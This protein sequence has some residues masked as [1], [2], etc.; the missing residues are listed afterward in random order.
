MS[1]QSDCACG[2]SC[3]DTTHQGCGCNAL[4]TGP[5]TPEQPCTACDRDRRNNVWVE[6]AV[7]S[8]GVG[9]ICLLDTLCEQQI[10]DIIQRDERARQ[11]L[12]RVTSNP[13][14]HKLAATVP[15]LPK[16][17]E[18]DELQKEINQNTIPFYTLF[19]GQ[20]PFAQ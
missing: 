6:G 19:R 15:R 13:E 11:D 4:P 5:V 3:P 17:N 1:C 9:G 8:N 7:D 2:G 16:V 18:G 14:L 12:C 10:V 20:P